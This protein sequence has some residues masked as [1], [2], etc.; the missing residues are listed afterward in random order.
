MSV[1]L[2]DIRTRHSAGHQQTSTPAYCA[3][4]DGLSA[5][6]CEVGFLLWRVDVLNK[7]L[8]RFEAALT[9]TGDHHALP[10][11]YCLDCGGACILPAARENAEAL[12]E[13]A[14][15]GPSPF[16]VKAVQP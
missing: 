8:R 1:T 6:Y 10:D 12:R 13:Q 15:A 9:P 7:A 14:Y 4:N 16:A 3:V 5:V 2:D 11:G